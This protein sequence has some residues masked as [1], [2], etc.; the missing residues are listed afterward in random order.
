[1]NVA[2]AQA[3]PGAPEGTWCFALTNGV[4]EAEASVV[5]SV[6][7]TG[8]PYRQRFLMQE[9]Q[10]MLGAPDCARGDRNVVEIRSTALNDEGAKLAALPDN[11]VAF[12]F[13][14]LAR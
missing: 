3:R 1:M 12:A 4:R 5:V 9:A 7:N 2:L 8:G 14:V 11:E 13:S 6:A 10:W